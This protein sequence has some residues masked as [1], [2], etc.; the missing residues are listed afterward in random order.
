MSETTKDILERIASALEGIETAAMV[1]VGLWDLPTQ[2]EPA[3]TWDCT[4]GLTMGLEVDECPNCHR[5][6]IDTD[7][8]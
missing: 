8:K 3:T 2:E 5:K 1:S 7:A 4:C 6:N